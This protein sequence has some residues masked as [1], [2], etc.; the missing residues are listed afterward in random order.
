MSGDLWLI[1]LCLSTPRTELS[2]L[3][4][5]ISELSVEHMNIDSECVSRV[6]GSPPGLPGLRSPFHDKVFEWRV[7]NF[8]G[9][10]KRL[11]LPHNIRYDNES[12]VDGCFGPR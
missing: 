6:P 8:H 5:Q 4:E 11:G 9:S 1:G 2:E 7:R 3:F 10:R 12:Y